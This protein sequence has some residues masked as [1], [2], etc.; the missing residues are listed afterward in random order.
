[1]IVLSFKFTCQVCGND[2][3]F[4]AMPCDQLVNNGQDTVQS[5]TEFLLRCKKCGQKYRLKYSLER[6]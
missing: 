3:D 6:V 2:K 1:M 4:Y 5:L